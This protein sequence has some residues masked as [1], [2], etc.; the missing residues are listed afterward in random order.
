MSSKYSVAFIQSCWH[1]DIVDQF[2]HSFDQHLQDIEN[3]EVSIEY[4]EAPGVV[5]V[6]LLARRCAESPKYDIIVVCAND[7][8]IT[9]TCINQINV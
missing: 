9:S 2:R 7:G 3:N 8:I 4:F 6:P 5:E 1:K